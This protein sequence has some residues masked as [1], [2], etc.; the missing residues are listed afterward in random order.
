MP[1]LRFFVFFLAG[2]AILPCYGQERCATVPYMERLRNQKLL[3]ES[4]AHFEEWMRAKRMFTP[5]VRGTDKTKS[6]FV[7]PVVVHVIHNGEG[8]GSGTNI[9]EAQILSQID[10]LN[11]DYNRNNPDASETP[12][13]FS[14]L[15]GNPEIE[16]VLAR[17]DPE[18]LP[19]N[20]IVRVK[21]SKPVWNISDNALFKS[22]SY[23]PSDNY[24]NIWV[25]N[26][27][28]FIGYAQSPVSTLPGL[29]NSSSNALTDGLVIHYRAF[30]SN[31]KGNFNLL[32]GFDRGRT[33]THEIGHY[34]GLIHIWG[35][36]GGACTGTDYV[37][38]TPNQAGS[39]QSC[40]S[41]PRMS[42]SNTIMFQNFM[43][44]TSDQCMNL[45]TQGQVERM[46]IVLMNSPRRASL[47]ES[48]G[49]DEPVPVANDVGIRS[50]VTPGDDVCP[51]Q[52]V[53]SL[54][55]RNYGTDVVTSVTIRVFLDG[56]EKEAITFPLQLEPLASAVVNFSPVP[57]VAGQTYSIRF[58]VLDVNGSVDQRAPNNTL[59]ADFTIP[60]A[61]GLPLSEDF[62]AF[63]SAWTVVNADERN[64]WEWQNLS[65]DYAMMID[66]HK[67]P[68]NLGDVD[69]LLTPV[70]DFSDAEAG[71]LSF[72]ISYAHVPGKSASLM[73]LAIRGCRNN[74]S[75]LDQVVYAKFDEALSTA[76]NT[77]LEHTPDDPS[78]WRTEVINLNA[79]IGEP[80]L[81]LAF[82][83]ING[84]GNRLFIDNV[85]VQS[86]AYE[87]VEIVDLVQPGPV[88]CARALQPTLRI[89]NKGTDITSL[90]VVASVN[91]SPINST[92]PAIIPT[93]AE[94]I[95]ELN[96]IILAPGEN[97]LSFEVQ[98]VNNVGDRIPD[99]NV[100]SR[101]VISNTE[102]DIVPLR[103]T[104]ED[105]AEANWFNVSQGNMPP[106][107]TVNYNN[108]TSLS[109]P[110]FELAPTDGSA[111]FVS[112]LLDLSGVK[113]ASISFE[114][115]Y[116]YEPGTSDR[117][118]V[119][120][121]KDCSQYDTLVL[122]EGDQIA[123]RR[124]PGGWIPS[125]P[126]DWSRINLSLSALEGQPES[127]VAFVFQ[128]GGGNNFYLDNI[129]IFVTAN[130]QGID[131]E[132]AVYPNP[133]S[134]QQ[135]PK[136][137]FNFTQRSTVNLSII[138]ITGQ[139]VF[140]TY[141]ENLL[142]QT[143][144]LPVYDLLPGVYII[145]T[146]TS[147]RQYRHRLI[148]TH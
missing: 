27:E 123:F 55:I 141:L 84:G 140:S 57:V 13:E 134:V 138:A 115:S 58:E 145:N 37:D 83:A 108:N 139:E 110:G 1:L 112:P 114:L 133:A 68:Q 121:S 146:T 107:A 65:G 97:N 124:E 54:D 128:D 109:I 32:S 117:F 16:F 2:W 50:I 96:E 40:P 79:F 6:R 142:N 104:F 82:V 81:R 89:R 136:I 47:L 9:S 71:L 46:E 66:W 132:V 118:G 45:F 39:T 28:S 52:I 86:E 61:I 75:V 80:A 20:G 135:L 137:S 11:E 99:N 21:G 119:L 98:K 10:V 76:P 64:T 113:N 8:E 59:Q 38:D 106:W 7:I 126:D 29:E 62:S 19:T 87:D 122:L 102:R 31:A 67:H 91:G 125:G 63:P 5:R 100:I 22:L 34:L 148:I 35:D 88:T 101:T 144:E 43:D 131:G 12:P 3:L 56:L 85:H 77:P 26:L 48:P 41:H 36:D 105:D 90:E 103:L 116:A 70:L 130:P 42:C 15:A 120:Y 129:E 4:P 51:P 17:Q 60:S 93:G 78:D 143:Y 72:D 95:L 73:V 147:E 23:W 25:I 92:Y 69:G 111:W 49:A 94:Y 33:S 18:G 30:G 127:R 74:I 53:P 14:P 24:L 44:Y